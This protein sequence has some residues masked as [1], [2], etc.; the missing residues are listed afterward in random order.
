M[1]QFL[2]YDAPGPGAAGIFRDAARAEDALA[3][4][5]GVRAFVRR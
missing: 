4:P 3:P 2:T 1:I 5:I